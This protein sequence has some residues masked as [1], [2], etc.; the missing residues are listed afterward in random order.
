MF[1]R[2]LAP[3][4]AL[5][6]LSLSQLVACA[7]MGRLRG[8]LGTTLENDFAQR[9]P[10]ATDVR[11]DREVEV[12]AL[13]LPRYRIVHYGPR[14]LTGRAPAVVFL[15]GRFAPEGQYD[16]YARTLASHGF[17]VVMHSQYS[18][19]Y[20]DDELRRDAVEMGNWLRARADVDPARIAVA[21]HSMGGRD[22]IW[23]AAEDPRVSAVVAIDPGTIE[24]MRHANE[25]LARIHV[26][27]LLIGADAAWRGM[28][29]CGRR[30]T[31]YAA[32]FEHSPDTTTL[33]EIHGADH[34]QVMDSP[35]A[36]GY[37]VCRVGTADSTSVRRATRGAL[38]QFL[39]ERL[40][41]APRHAESYGALA[42][43]SVRQRTAPAVALPATATASASATRG[44]E[45]A[46]AEAHDGGATP[47]GASM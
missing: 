39:S 7:P 29:F 35:D 31:N 24:R 32:Y 16:S 17:V 43:L 23:A 8:G 15:P 34:V 12:E 14:G 38:L 11:G 46:H 6:A 20:S 25:T 26:P 30:G 22:A 3:L 40:Q 33:L 28:E 27:M 21:G 47:P 4:F 41:S 10:R 44:D 9:T 42:T 13:A 5:A 18:W 37:S 2:P 45:Q 1:R 36:F 19:F